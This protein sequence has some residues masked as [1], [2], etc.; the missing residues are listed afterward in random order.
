VRYRHRPG[1]L[2]EP[3]DTSVAPDDDE[4]DEDA[5]GP[6]E[7]AAPNGSQCPGCPPLASLLQSD[8]RRRR[9][10]LGVPLRRAVAHRVRRDRRMSSA[11]QRAEVFEDHNTSLRV[12]GPP[13]N[14]ERTC[15][16]PCLP[17]KRERNIQIDGD[18]C[19]AAGE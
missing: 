10:I 8:S 2:R 14:R 13:R 12:P 11:P 18:E 3:D 15:G 16:T 5:V 19:A 17:F 6:R 1:Y 4:V 7:P 9:D